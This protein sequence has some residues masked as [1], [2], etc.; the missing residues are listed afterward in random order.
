M[1]IVI[2]GAG[3]HGRVVLDIL[4]ASNL[5]RPV[6]FIDA[7]PALAG[8]RVGG[9][10]VAGQANLLPKLRSQKVKG[11]IIAIGDNRARVRYARM[12]AE[13]GFELINAIHPSAVVSPTAKL[14]QNIVIAAG[15]V[16]GTDAELSDSVLVNTSAVI[17]HECR[18]G[19][20]AHLC[21]AAALAGRV[22]V[23]DGAFVGLGCRVIQCLSVGAHATIGAGSVVIRDVPA[24][25]TVVGVPARVIKIAATEAAGV[26]RV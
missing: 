21:P 10:P 23:G 2:V 9:V 4:R 14:G 19:E 17:D 20:G 6:A 22:R 3:G 7:D 12:A 13:Q 5:H 18:I 16:I 15:A 11:A 25:A 1:D 8:S 26:G 24:D